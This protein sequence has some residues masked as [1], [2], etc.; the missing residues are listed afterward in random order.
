MSSCSMSCELVTLNVETLSSFKIKRLA[1]EDFIIGF[2]F[3]WSI[4]V[5]L[6]SQWKKNN[7]T[8]AA[9]VVSWRSY[10][11]L[12]SQNISCDALLSFSATTAETI[13]YESRRRFL[14]IR[15][16]SWSRDYCCFSHQQSQNLL[17]IK[18]QKKNGLKSFW[19]SAE[20]SYYLY[21]MDKS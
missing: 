8:I 4:V 9:C 3:L 13:F 17:I 5:I 20:F 7:A 21:I 10:G 2:S 19:S 12:L 16:Y 14:L 6:I 11:A 15:I 18:Q 1:T